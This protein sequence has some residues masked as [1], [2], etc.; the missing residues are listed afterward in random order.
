MQ[1]FLG[2]DLAAG[3]TDPTGV[4]DI[5]TYTI[6][7]N[8]AFHLWDLNKSHDI[9]FQTPD[10]SEDK[11]FTFPP[12]SGIG[13][14][15][16]IMFKNAVQI[17]TG[18]T[19]DFNSNT[20]LNI[21]KAAL[22][23]VVFFKDQ[24]NVLGAN[25]FDISN[26]TGVVGTPA[27]GTRRFH[28]DNATGKLSVKRSDGVIV[29]LE[30]GS[31]ASA[32]GFAA[33]GTTNKSANGSTTVFTIAHGLANVPD[34]V[35]VQP[36][37]VE[38]NADRKVEKDATNITITYNVP[39]PTSTLTFIWGA[40]YVNPDA[41]AFHATSIST[42]Q[43]KTINLDQNTV[44]HSTTNLAGDIVRSDGT[45]FNRFAKGTAFQL[46]RTNSG[47]TDIEYVSPASIF[48]AHYDLST[49]SP[50][51][52]PGASTVRVYGKVNDANNDALV[53]KQKINGAVKEVH[54]F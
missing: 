11:I 41:I 50:P 40:A 9:E 48:N 43:N 3:G 22:P 34:V 18:K 49:I 25:L 2:T 14:T 52:D 19:I 26:F 33:G 8:A 39:P 53:V 31:A 32:G 20:I 45:K 27:S 10:Y 51:A 46:L 47:A 42:M 30:E 5:A 24:D 29:S 36:T 7:S 44:K 16:E 21:T 12:E 4:A 38:G 13:A 17:V 54:N 35:V 6:F 37:T 28:V 23:S 1:Y 15:D